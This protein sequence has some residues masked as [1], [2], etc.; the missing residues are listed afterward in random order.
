[1]IREISRVIAV[2]NEPLYKPL[3][4]GIHSVRHPARVSANRTI[5][6]STC[7]THRR[8]RSR[9]LE[10]AKARFEAIDAIHFPGENLHRTID[11][12]ATRRRLSETTWRRSRYSHGTGFDETRL[13][14]VRDPED[15]VRD[16]PR[17]ISAPR[18][19]RTIE[20]ANG[21]TPFAARFP[22]S[23]VR[24]GDY[25][26]PIEGPS[27]SHRRSRVPGSRG[28]G[29]GTRLLAEVPPRLTLIT[30]YH[31][32]RGRGREEEGFL[33]FEISIRGSV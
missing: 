17:L 20:P 16:R 22:G 4:L 15:E 28:K 5:I 26:S 7:S 9:K 29:R 19:N 12:T 31:P 33:R 6:S 13:R 3:S 30:E 23:P 21:I 2:P 24:G 10:F 32:D 25:R 14:T 18:R 11:R 1:V 8:I 27:R